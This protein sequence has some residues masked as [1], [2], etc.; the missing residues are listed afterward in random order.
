M[1]SHT[2]EFLTK[3]ADLMEE[4]SANMEIEGDYYSGGPMQV[5]LEVKNPQ[6]FD[7]HYD[8]WVA[9]NPDKKY[10]FHDQSTYSYAEWVDLGFHFDANDVRGEIK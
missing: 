8:Q 2:R 5:T 3:L 9:E 4:Y 6:T 10:P 1:N 7:E